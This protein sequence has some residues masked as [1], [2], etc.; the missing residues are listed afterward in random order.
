MADPA[1]DLEKLRTDLA[2]LTKKVDYMNGAAVTITQMAPLMKRVD[3]LEDDSAQLAK[4]L[5]ALEDKTKN[6]K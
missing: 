3:K 6:L 2:A 5:K 4:R 1:A